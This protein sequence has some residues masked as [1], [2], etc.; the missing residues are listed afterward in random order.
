MPRIS[1]SGEIVLDLTVRPQS[2][3]RFTRLLTSDSGWFPSRN[4]I[5]YGGCF[6]NSIPSILS[7]TPIKMF[8]VGTSVFFPYLQVTL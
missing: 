6:Q 3:M 2:R 4:P 5:V 1:E 8:E 7:A